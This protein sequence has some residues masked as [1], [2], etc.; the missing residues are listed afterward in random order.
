MTDLYTHLERLW[1]S[2]G[3]KN[4]TE[5]CKAS[6]ISRSLLTELKKGRTKELSGATAQKLANTLNVPLDVIYGKSLNDS[7]IEINKPHTVN[8]VE[9]TDAQAEAWQLIKNM[10]D[11]AL[12]RFVA[13]AKAALLP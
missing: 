11:D 13:I 4:V 6:G 10:D 7:I 12:K 1:T 2:R 3:Y 8:G 9:L 5:L